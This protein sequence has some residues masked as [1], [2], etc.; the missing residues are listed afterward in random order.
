MP[1]TTFTPASAS[2][3][4][5]LPLLGNGDVYDSD[6]LASPSSTTGSAS[7]SDET[8]SGTTTTT[9][10]DDD[11]DGDNDDWASY[12]SSPA[13]D[14]TFSSGSISP[15]PLPGAFWRHSRPANG[16]HRHKKKTK[17]KEQ[18]EIPQRSR[19]VS[20]STA[21]SFEDFITSTAAAAATGFATTLPPPSLPASLDVVVDSQ[22][23][24]NQARLLLVSL[25]ETFCMMYSATDPNATN[26]HQRLFTLLCQQL[27]NLG[28]ISEA[29]FHDGFANVRSAYSRAFKD[30][31]TQAL[32][33]VKKEQGHLI[34][35]AHAGV[36]GNNGHHHPLHRGLLQYH[37]HNTHRPSSVLNHHHKDTTGSPSSSSQSPLAD[38]LDYHATRYRTDFVE[39]SKLGKGGFG[40]VWRVQHRLDD[41]EY[42]VKKIRIRQTAKSE[43]ILR[44]VKVLAR[45]DHPNIVRYYSAWLENDVRMS[46]PFSGDSS[47]YDDDSG[48]T[49]IHTPDSLSRGT[50]LSELD[51]DFVDSPHLEGIDIVVPPRSSNRTPPQAPAP[52]RDSASSSKSWR[53]P[54]A[55]SEGNDD[56]AMDNHLPDKWPLTV[57]IQM[58]LCQSTLHDYLSYKNDSRLPVHP[59]DNYYILAGLLRAVEYIHAKGITHRDI[60]P[61]NCFL[62]HGHE[63][64][65]GTPAAA[66][67][68]HSDISPLLQWLHLQRY[69]DVVVKLGDFGLVSDTQSPPVAAAAAAAAAAA[70]NSPTPAMQRLIGLTTR[71]APDVSSAVSCSAVVP[72]LSEAYTPGLGT[73]TYSAPEQ[74]GSGSGSSSSVS[75]APF[76]QQQAFTSDIY[77]LGVILFELFHRFATGMERILVLQQLRQGVLP[78]DFIEAFPRE[79]ALVLWMM[80][81]DPQQRPAASD[82][83]R[84]VEDNIL[85]ERDVMSLQPAPANAVQLSFAAVAP[86]DASQNELAPAPFPLD[87]KLDLPA[88]ELAAIVQTQAQQL[89]RQ[90][91]EIA[92]LHETIKRLE[93]QLSISEGAGS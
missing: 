50:E 54:Q 22:V 33:V 72:L 90:H 74:L 11:G 51:V 3:Q 58:Q 20:T 83:L 93:L 43:R 37:H 84:I 31:V 21:A 35:G 14:A 45:L 34:D 69:E 60:T 64:R 66:A 87:V 57:F 41:L 63:R 8:N 28:V 46:H 29:D 36:N 53:Q 59:M 40:S 89:H 91:T 52:L 32:S 47:L 49:G 70:G 68:A 71:S 13:A 55:V 5:Q 38:L 17:K 30:L 9:D 78:P 92:L 1:R 81:A 62:F 85:A 6:N 10:D 86:P 25:L 73:S 4:Q 61:R 48:S 67:A 12:S 24:R 42:A 44:E 19:K 2:A 88:S 23:K 79:A 65:F 56:G 82:L 75:T 16:K 77:S 76:F 15:E 80:A 39:I 7:D 26:S 18:I 27:S